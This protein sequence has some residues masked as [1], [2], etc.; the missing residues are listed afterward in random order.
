MSLAY[1]TRCV[2]ATIELLR[3]E[4]TRLKSLLTVPRFQE[5]RAPRTL[6]ML[7]GLSEHAMVSKCMNEDSG[8]NSIQEVQVGSTLKRRHLS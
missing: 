1:Y 4:V 2:E 6:W 5:P 7:E 8:G 3:T